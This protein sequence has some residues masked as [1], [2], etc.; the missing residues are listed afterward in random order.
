MDV[1]VPVAKDEMQFR[2][3]SYYTQESPLGT[4]EKKPTNDLPY[5]ISY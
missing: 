1:T 4:A 5:G 3:V 2:K